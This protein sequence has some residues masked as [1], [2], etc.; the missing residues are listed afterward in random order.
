MSKRDPFYDALFPNDG[1]HL[2]LDPAARKATALDLFGA[3]TAAAMDT[4]VEESNSLV[5]GQYT[6]RERYGAIFENQ[7]SFVEGLAGLSSE[8]RA[9]VRR[10]IRRTSSGLLFWY[11]SKLSQF[12]GLLL[13][14]RLQSCDPQTDLLSDVAEIRDEDLYCHFR[15]WLDRFSDTDD[16]L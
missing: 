11:L 16:E 12:P 14:I 8:Q 10:L 15:D 4:V 9:V 2:P 6:V 3:V 13:T 5:D 1:L 7:R